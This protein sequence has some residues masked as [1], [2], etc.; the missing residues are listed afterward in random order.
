MAREYLAFAD[1]YGAH[2]RMVRPHLFQMLYSSLRHRPDLLAAL[3]Q[4][5]HL[6][7]KGALSSSL[8]LS[9]S[10]SIYICIYIY[11]V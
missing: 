9:L 4:C 2:Y 3:A 1:E 10:L 7:G 11:N 6:P 8:S 5:K